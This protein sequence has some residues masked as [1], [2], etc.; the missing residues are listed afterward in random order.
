M[1]RPLDRPDVFTAPKAQPSWQFPPPDGLAVALKTDPQARILVG[2]R[3]R[4]GMKAR[5]Y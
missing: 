2:Y 5:A 1:E 4:A 3:W